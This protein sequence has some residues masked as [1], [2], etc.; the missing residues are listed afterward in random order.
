MKKMAKGSWVNEGG[1]KF[2]MILGLYAFV[3]QKRFTDDKA[4]FAYLIK[5]RISIGAFHTKQNEHFNYAKRLYAS[6]S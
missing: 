1:T 2:H 6:N 5:S 4:L 3:L